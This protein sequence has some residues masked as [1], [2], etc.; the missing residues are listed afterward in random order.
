[1]RAG[2]D[3]GGAA[4]AGRGALERAGGVSYHPQPVSSR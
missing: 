2:I 3:S 1:M 4:I